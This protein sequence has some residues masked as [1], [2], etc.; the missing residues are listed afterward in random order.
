MYDD[1]ATHDGIIYTIVVRIGWKEFRSFN[2]AL[3]IKGYCPEFFLLNL[4]H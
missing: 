3:K 4:L 2:K 1:E